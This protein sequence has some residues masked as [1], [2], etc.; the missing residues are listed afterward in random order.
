MESKLGRLLPLLAFLGFLLELLLFLDG[1][2]LLLLPKVTQGSQPGLALACPL[3]EQLLLLLLGSL[4]RLCRS[5]GK[6][7][8]SGLRYQRKMVNAG[9]QPHATKQKKKAHRER[10]HSTVEGPAAPASGF[11]M[12][13]P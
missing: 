1:F 13:M 2:L 8:S 6:A 7:D 11:L 12:V 10:G 5:D 9:P 4:G 3:V